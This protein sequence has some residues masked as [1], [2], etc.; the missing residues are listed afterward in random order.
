VL[1]KTLLFCF[2]CSTAWS[3]ELLVQVA[4]SDW[5]GG[6][7]AGDVIVVD[8]DGTVWGGSEG[9]PTY[10]VIKL[11]GIAVD[12]VKYMEES[13]TEEQVV[14]GETVEVVTE[15]RKYHA[16]MVD[17]NRALPTGSMT[18]S[19][20]NVHSYVANTVKNKILEAEAGE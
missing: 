9:P 16:P 7:K 4:D 18:V 6:P 12:D 20:G 10:V 13:V 19:T 17:V 11:P 15:F 1:L 2:I 3:A 8:A 14:E 5:E